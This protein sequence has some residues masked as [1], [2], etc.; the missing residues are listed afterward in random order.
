[1]KDDELRLV[2]VKISNTVAY[3]PSIIQGMKK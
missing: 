3:T 2:S 1:M